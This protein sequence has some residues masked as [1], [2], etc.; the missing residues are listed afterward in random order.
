MNW[1]PRTVWNKKL[2][3][4]VIFCSSYTKCRLLLIEALRYPIDC[5]VTRDILVVSHSTVSTQFSRSYCDIADYRR[6]SSLSSQPRPVI[7]VGL[8]TALLIASFTFIRSCASCVV[9]VLVKVSRKF[10][11]FSNPICVQV[12]P[13][14]LVQS[15][16][17]H[18]ANHTTS[19][20]YC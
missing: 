10:F 19:V 12:H 18:S 16:R 9:K 13:W 3:S 17:R 15:V 6:W 5:L 8:E 11:E 4:L 14:H 2:I 20:T 7:Y 1:K